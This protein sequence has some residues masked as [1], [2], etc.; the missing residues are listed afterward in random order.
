MSGILTALY[1]LQMLTESGSG[2]QEVLG[3]NRITTRYVKQHPSCLIQIS[4]N[5][6]ASASAKKN[7]LSQ[8]KFPIV[9]CLHN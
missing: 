1:T 2:Q 9:Q 6:T 5:A 4:L 7:R 8:N 3:G